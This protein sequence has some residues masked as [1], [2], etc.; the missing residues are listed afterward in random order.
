MTESMTNLVGALKTHGVTKVVDL[1]AH[2]VGDSL[3]TLFFMMRWIVRKSNMSIAFE[4]H[5]SAGSVLRDSGLTFVLARPTRFTEDSAAPIK[6]YGNTGHGIG[7]FAGM[8]RKSTAVFLVNAA[9]KR[10]WDG[11]APVM[12]N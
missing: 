8:S 4:D 9:E 7:S 11:T 1:Q 5:E 12:S 2:G 6:F 3:P 10:D